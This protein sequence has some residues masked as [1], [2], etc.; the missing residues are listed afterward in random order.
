MY[1]RSLRCGTPAISSEKITR[2]QMMYPHRSSAALTWQ[3]Q[4][5]VAEF[6]SK[7]G[8]KLW[9]HLAKRLPVIHIQQVAHVLEQQ[10]PDRDTQLPLGK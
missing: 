1:S 3:R 4:R 8:I 7:R 5:V 6:P 2:R 10:R 9:N